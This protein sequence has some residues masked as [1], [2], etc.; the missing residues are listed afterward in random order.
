MQLT[1]KLN[2]TTETLLKALAEASG[3]TPETLAEAL[4]SDIVLSAA[5]NPEL[6]GVD[7]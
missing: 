5:E 7:E 2:E 4:L 6:I 3:D 1:L